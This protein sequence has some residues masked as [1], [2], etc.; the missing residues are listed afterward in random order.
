MADHEPTPSFVF[1]KLM[2]RLSPAR[3]AALV[4][5][6]NVIGNGCDAQAVL[7]SIPDRLRLSAVDRSLCTEL[8]YGYCRLEGRLLA[9]TGFF[10]KKPK[11]LPPLV[12][13]ILALAALEL[14]TLDRIPEYASVNWAVDAVRAGFG[15]GLAGLVNAVLRNVCRLGPDASR[16]EFFAKNLKDRMRFLGAWYSQPSWIIEHFLKTY[17]E[18]RALAFLETFVATP[19]AGL[20]VNMSRPGAKR[21]LEALSLTCTA[22]LGAAL[23][24]APRDV[25]ESVDGE[26]LEALLAEGRISRQGFGAQEAMFRLMEA[27]FS[28]PVWDACCGRGGKSCMLLEQ[29]AAVPFASDLN[30]RRL[31]GFRM[32][33][34][35]LRLPA[36]FLFRADAALPPLRMTPQ[37]VL[38][39]IPCSGLGTL[40]RRPDIKYHR[41]ASDLARLAG[42]QARIA[43]GLTAAL[44]PGGKLAWLTCTVNP[45][46]NELAVRA[47]LAHSA[48]KLDYEFA[49]PP[50]SPGAEFFYAALLRKSR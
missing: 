44:R 42:L 24:F 17:S 35:R 5:L 20:R 48:L 2:R 8:T 37:A 7:N 47:M 1:P 50:D 23:A 26:A 14:T 22:R 49:T 10:L 36:P 34:E 19:S 18:E 4:C 28:G 38:A 40:A 11:Q 13:R 46:E 21:L 15:S 45:G 25:P 41:S 12:R 9:L 29:G 33:L 3:R 27:G 30:A 39:D 31:A 6:E 32:E 16:P 43:G